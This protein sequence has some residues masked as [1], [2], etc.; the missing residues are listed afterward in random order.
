MSY[1]FIDSPLVTASIERPAAEAIEAARAFP[2][3]T[4]LEAANKLGAL[5]SA[6]K[7]VSPAFRVCGPAVTV[8]SP[9]G[10]NLWLHRALVV[11]QPGDVLVVYTSDYYEAGYWGEVMSTAAKE[12]GVA[13]L[14]IDGCVRDAEL[15]ARIGFPVFSRGLC[16]R[17][18]TKDFAARGW[19]NHPLRIGDVAVRPGDLVVGDA[20]GVVV[21]AQ[22][23]IDAT[24]RAASERE[25]TEAEILARIAAGELTLD[26]YGWN[27]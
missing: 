5:P 16:I 13:G 12:R 18:T 3:A 27:R 24:L 25:D 21:L 10:D 7:P 2:S 11:A 19:I 6:I 17:G 1:P 9:P 20:D 14:V 22:E 8:H 23:S 26:I 15:L 4:L